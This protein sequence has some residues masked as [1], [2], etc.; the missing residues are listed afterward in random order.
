MLLSDY[1]QLIVPA[2]P[3]LLPMMA[4]D[5]ENF[6]GFMVMAVES[7]TLRKRPESGAGL[8]FIVAED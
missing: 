4:K 1:S 7:T 5:P 8:P 6:L 2:M 3:P